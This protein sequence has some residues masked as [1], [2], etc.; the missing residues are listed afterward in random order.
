MN[1]SDR[2]RTAIL[3]SKKTKYAIAIGAG[4]DHAVLRRF[5]KKER[6]IKLRTAEQLA[7]FLDLELVKKRKR[8]KV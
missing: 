5:L 1:L 2:L 4:V 6:D 8:R 7:E 3:T